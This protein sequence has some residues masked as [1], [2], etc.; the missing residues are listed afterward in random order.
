MDNSSVAEFYCCDTLDCFNMTKPPQEQNE[1]LLRG[2]SEFDVEEL[3]WPSSPSN[4]LQ[5]GAGFT[6]VF[7][8]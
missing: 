8:C 2:F 3:D 4:N 6:K 7:K 1:V 5:P